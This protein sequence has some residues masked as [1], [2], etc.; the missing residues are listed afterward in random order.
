MARSDRGDPS[1]LDSARAGTTPACRYERGIP[2]IFCRRGAEGRPFLWTAHTQRGPGKK[3]QKSFSVGRYG[4]SA[5]DMAI[6]E[7]EWQ[8]TQMRGVVF[9]LLDVKGRRLLEQHAA[10]PEIA[11]VEPVPWPMPSMGCRNQSNTSGFSGGSL[12]KSRNG[13]PRAWLART[14]GGQIMQSKLLPIAKHGDAKAK[15]LAIM[16][17]QRRL[18][19]AEKASTNR[20]TMKID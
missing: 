1:C 13:K 16:E 17:R 2:G 8:L 7:R 15:E 3:L 14:R 6:R 10:E 19:R 4:D 9:G 18:K 5:R 11:A 12:L 20:K